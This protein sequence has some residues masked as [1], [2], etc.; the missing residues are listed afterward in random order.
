M[1]LLIISPNFPNIL[2]GISDYC[3]NLAIALSEKGHDVNVITSDNE[4]ISYDSRIS[5]FSFIKNWD[6]KSVNKLNNQIKNINPDYLLF[7]YEPYMY[8]QRGIPVYLLV[9]F[10][11]LDL[12]KIKL[13]TTFHEIGRRLD[14]RSPKH[15]FIG[16]IQRLVAYY[17]FFNSQKIIITLKRYREMIPR[18]FLRKTIIIPVGSSINPF[19]LS[20]EEK[21][22]IK[23]LVSPN[24]NPVIT[25]YG[26]SINRIHSLCNI[27]KALNNKGIRLT[28]QIIGELP[29]NSTIS[30]EIKEN[31]LEDQFY[32]TGYLDNEKIYKHL[33]ISDIYLQLE[34]Y[35]DYGSVGISTKSTSLVSAYAAG[36]PVIGSEG[37]MTDDFFTHGKNIYYVKTMDID[38]V[39]VAIRELLDNKEILLKLRNGA[40][41]IFR[42]KL[43]WEIIS[44]KYIEHMT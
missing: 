10:A 17:I 30:E 32:I 16:M 27:L 1:K 39:A 25:V 29:Q 22:K 8:N 11:L 34:G 40:E 24:I 5:T 15:L 38:E 23:K 33:V 7:Q 44:S 35:D 14:F 12:K 31:G 13:I 19:T 42:E 9:F 28:I 41:K 43:S 36:L 3:F 4:N 21:Q 6:L 26:T 18:L 20:I 2:G 37:H